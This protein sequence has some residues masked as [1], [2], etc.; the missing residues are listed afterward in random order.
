MI[1][2]FRTNPGLLVGVIL[3]AMGTLIL[4]GFAFWMSRSGASLRPIAWLAGF[5]LLILVPQFAG[6]LVFA[7]RARRAEAPR[8]AALAAA[9]TAPDAETRRA[10][11]VQWLG[12]DADPALVRDARPVFGDV[13][14]AAEEAQ[15]AALP[16]GESVLFARFRGAL[17][18][19]KAW[20]GYLRVTGFA[21]IK[22]A[23]DSQ[24]GFVVT[25]PA[26]DR[27]YA[28]HFGNCVGVWTGADDAMIRR[29]MTAGGFEIPRRAPLAGKIEP[30]PE[31]AAV[32]SANRLGLAWKIFAGVG[33]AAYLLVVVAYFL[34]GS[35][36]AGG[37]PAVAGAAVRDEA[38]LARQFAQLGAA[39]GAPFTVERGANE[40][41]WLV[42]WRYADATW[43]DHARAHGLRKIHRLRIVLDGAGRTARVTD[44]ESDFD[45][46]AGAD[47][48]RLAWKASSGI[49]F[50]KREHQ[51]VFGLQLEAG[52]DG[53]PA[54]HS[55]YTFDLQ[56]LKRPF[57]DAVTGAGWAWRPVVWDAPAG[58]RWL[59]E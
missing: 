40:H 36:W 21:Q 37:E 26:G 57:I 27:A 13:F 4:G 22:G 15:F 10:A 44:F 25:R 20:V 39:A 30:G 24:R 55:S 5:F 34:K 18:A 58:L 53:K 50:F 32:P 54:L 46:D 9:Q 19:E 59:A 33:L 41:E 3:L 28:L 43:L 56:E 52:A 29:R 38:E 45:W 16:T 1:A 12:P 11:L 49:V 17:A 35:A 8:A 51:R 42:T 47:G 7:L 31:G 23:G 14:A 6:H 48:V 2:L